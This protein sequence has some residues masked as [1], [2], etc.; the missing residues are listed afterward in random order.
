MPFWTR[1]KTRKESTPA[2]DTGQVQPARAHQ[3]LNPPA[4][5][6]VKLLAMEALDSDLTVKEAAEIVRRCGQQ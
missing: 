3:K 5:L 6:E 2:G 1:H 4:P